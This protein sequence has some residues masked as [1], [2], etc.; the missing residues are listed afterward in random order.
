VDN[1]VARTAGSLL[2]SAD[3]AAG[4]DAGVGENDAYIA[5]MA[6]ILDD[7]VLTENTDDFERLGVSTESY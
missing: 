5:A 7:S 6:D 1:E 2:A 4:G 3:D